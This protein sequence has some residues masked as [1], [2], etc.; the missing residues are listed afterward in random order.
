MHGLQGPVTVNGQVYDGVMPALRLTDDEVANVLTYVYSQWG[1]AGFVVTP[2][3][4]AAVRRS[5]GPSGG[6]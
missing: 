6:H 4:V 1:N 5:R 2:N 3:E